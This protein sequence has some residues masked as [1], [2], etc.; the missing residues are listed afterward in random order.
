VAEHH[1]IS[2]L[3]MKK[4]WTKAEIIALYNARKPPGAPPYAPTLAT[5]KLA[6]VFADVVDLLRPR[7]AAPQPRAVAEA[8]RG[9]HGV[10]KESDLIRAVE[11]TAR[12]I[13]DA[14]FV[15]R[16]AW[17]VDDNEHIPRVR[18]IALA[19]CDAADRL[20]AGTHA[21]AQLAKRLLQH[22]EG[23][24]LKRWMAE[25]EEGEDPEAVR[26]EGLETFVH[27]IAGGRI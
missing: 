15:L 16:E 19:A 25:L 13:I 14:E 18:T 6:Q 1:T 8:H 20:G 5:R 3:T 2:P 23:E 4:A 11:E 24:Y 7:R 12:S 10:S 26:Q 22:A 27:V 21:A 9:E 17:S